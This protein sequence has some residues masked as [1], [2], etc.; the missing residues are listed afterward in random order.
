MMGEPMEL[1]RVKE[2][3]RGRHVWILWET[4]FY[5]VRIDCELVLH[6][7]PESLKASMDGVNGH[8][9]PY[10]RYWYGWWCYEEQPYPAWE[11]DEE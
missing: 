10:S 11:G 7:T 6:N 1:E 4:S 2:L 5:C 8:E 3:E 9:W